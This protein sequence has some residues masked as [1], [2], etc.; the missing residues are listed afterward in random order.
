MIQAG[1]LTAL[2]AVTATGHYGRGHMPDN[3]STGP[4]EPPY[5]APVARELI[6]P[7]A[8]NRLI[9]LHGGFVQPT[10]EDS[11]ARRARGRLPG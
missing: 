10:A 5:G 1:S 4:P 8:R 3:K 11:A 6:G 7:G 9:W 2:R